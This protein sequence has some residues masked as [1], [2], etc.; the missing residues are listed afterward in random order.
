MWVN[1]ESHGSPPS[2]ER[3][4]EPVFFELG[5]IEGRDAGTM[6]VKMT[7]HMVAVEDDT[8]ADGAQ[9]LELA[10]LSPHFPIFQPVAESP[11]QRPFH[12]ALD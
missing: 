4:R 10:D 9:M 1:A 3:L 6:I 5:L 12:G 11:R 7:F 2:R 8:F